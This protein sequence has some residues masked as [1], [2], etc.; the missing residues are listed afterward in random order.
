ML[1]L[2]IFTSKIEDQF[3]LSRPGEASRYKFYLIMHEHQF[4]FRKPQPGEDLG[5]IRYSVW[6]PAAQP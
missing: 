5:R 6:R 3:F 4:V 1:K 2:S